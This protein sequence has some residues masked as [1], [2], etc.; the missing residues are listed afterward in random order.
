[1][2]RGTIRG[3]I[4]NV[5]HANLYFQGMLNVGHSGMLSG[6]SNTLVLSFNPHH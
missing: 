2:V 3:G 6:Y 1:M 5:K 4:I